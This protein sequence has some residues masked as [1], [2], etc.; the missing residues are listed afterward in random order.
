MHVMR[1]RAEGKSGGWRPDR[2]ETKLSASLGFT[3]V[4]ISV[5]FK[6]ISAPGLIKAARR[7]CPFAALHRAL[8]RASCVSRSCVLS[9]RAARARTPRTRNSRLRNE[10]IDVS[11]GSGDRDNRGCSPLEKFPS[12]SSFFRAT[13]VTTL[14][15]ATTTTLRRCLPLLLLR[16]LGST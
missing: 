14:V 3:A 12:D 10:A 11:A 8:H 1:A 5:T 16:V 15:L 7:F 2:S 9:M 6:R 4:S 13:K